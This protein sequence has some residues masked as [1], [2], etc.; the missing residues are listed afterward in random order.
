M[1]YLHINVARLNAAHMGATHSCF[2]IFC[3]GSNQIDFD[4][5]MFLF[6]KWQVI[7]VN[8]RMSETME[9][10]Q[11]YEEMFAH[12]YSSE[13][14]EYQEY[15]NRPADPPPIVEDWRGRGGGN[16]RGR[17]RRYQ[18]RQGGRGCGG[19]QEWGGGRSGRG[20][21]HRQQ[22]DRDRYGGHDRGSQPNSYQENSSHYHRPRYDRY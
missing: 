6:P 16:H 12:R 14:R 1:N 17:D 4:L 2:D 15:V 5:C 3:F 19:G 20:E 21:H 7:A 18:D 9:K 10:Q 8:Q 11:S 22:Q 13:D